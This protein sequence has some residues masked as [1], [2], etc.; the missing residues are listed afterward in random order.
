MIKELEVFLYRQTVSIFKIRSRNSHEKEKDVLRKK[1]ENV[2]MKFL[3][4]LHIIR[5]NFHD[6]R[7]F[8]RI[9]TKKK[10]KKIERIILHVKRNDSRGNSHESIT[11][12]RTLR[13]SCTHV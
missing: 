3:I 6:N 13:W 12:R 11:E 8:I 2:S 9:I 4:I 10:K 7:V 1:N 5:C